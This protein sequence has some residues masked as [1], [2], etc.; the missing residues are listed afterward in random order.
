MARFGLTGLR[1]ATAVARRFTGD[2]AAALFAGLAAHSILPLD[3]PLTT[4]FGV[5]L[6]ALGHLVGWPFAAGGSQA[7]TDALVAILAAHGG[8]VVCDHRV[9]ALDALPPS[10]VVLADVTPRQLVTIAGDRL[11]HRYRRRLER[12]RY[13][14][15]VFKVDYALSAPVPWADPAVAAGGDGAR[16]GHDGRGRRGR[17][18]GRARRASRPT[19]RARRPAEPV[20]PDA[21]ARRPPH[22][23]DLLPR[24]RRVDRRHDRAHRGPDRALRARLPRRGHRPPRHGAG[25]RSR[26]TTPTTTA[27]TSPPASPTGA[28]SPPARCCPCGR[29]RPRST[30]STSAPP[31]PRPAPASTACAASTPPASPSNGSDDVR[32]PLSDPNSP[33]N[34]ERAARRYSDRATRRPSRI[35]SWTVRGATQ[36]PACAVAPGSGSSGRRKPQS[37]TA[38]QGIVRRVPVNRSST[39]TSPGR[40][41]RSSVRRSTRTPARASRA[42]AGARSPV[43]ESSL[44]AMWSWVTRTARGA[45]L[46]GQGDADRPADRIEHDDVAFGGER[47]PHPGAARRRRPPPRRRRPRTP[48]A[49][50]RS[51]CTGSPRRHR[52]APPLVPSRT[53]TPSRATSRA[54]HATS[55]SFGPGDRGQAAQPRRPLDERHRVPADRPRP[56]PSPARPDLRRRRRRNDGSPPARTSRGPPSRAPSSARRCTSRA[57]C[58]RR[59]PGR[60]GCSGCTA[61]SARVLRRAAWRRGPGRRSAPGSSRRRRNRA[62][63]HARRA[64]IR[65]RPGRRRTPAG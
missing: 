30:A 45:E 3:R 13:G 43:R 39:S 34:R 60:S 33:E 55:G 31:P 17:G 21:G 61:G 57:G 51:R 9:D 62:V 24:A 2:P 44:P 14:P 56:G 63:R 64:P 48:A 65:P 11:P 18:G 35:A 49:R 7:I 40:T 36:S 28:S 47:R 50:R 37:T 6:G 12:F 10:R 19:V 16:R 27:A 26:P 22:P 42:L 32:E 4:A 46:L 1:G 59:A 23:V 20:R 38:A 53:S 54:S 58:A 5:T 29:G 8:E 52:P 41:A 15:G 25:R